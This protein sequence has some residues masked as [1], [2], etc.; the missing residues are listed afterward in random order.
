VTVVIDG[1]ELV[2]QVRQDLNTVG[3]IPMLPAHIY[4]ASQGRIGS[5]SDS[6]A[7]HLVV[8]PTLCTGFRARC[9]PPL[10]FSLGTALSMLCR[11]EAPFAKA[12]PAAATDPVYGENF[13]RNPYLAACAVW[14]AGAAPAS[15]HRALNSAVPVLIFHGQF[16]PYYPYST[17][18]TGAQGLRR[19]FLYDGT[20]LSYNVL[21]GNNCLLAMRNQWINDP[22]K[23]PELSCRRSLS[24]TVTDLQ[25]QVGSY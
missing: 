16:D 12:P 9:R 18:G 14:N 6:M 23:A 8:A 24:K 2:R 17:G 3:A 15:T 25:L 1:D 19:N 22:T 20:G 4:A 5:G 7:A 11:D 21:G 10:T 13:D